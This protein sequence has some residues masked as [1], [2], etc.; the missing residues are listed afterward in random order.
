MSDQR[1]PSLT[2]MVDF[3]V[4]GGPSLVPRHSLDRDVVA[5][6]RRLGFEWSILKA[7]EGST[8]ERA[9]LAGPGAVGGIVLNASVGGANPAAIE[10]AARYGARIVWM[11]TISA[12]AHRAAHDATELAILRNMPLSEVR[13]VEDGRL[14]PAW[15][16]VLDIVVARDLVLASGHIS[17]GEAVVLFTEAKRRGV[18]RMLINHPLM[19]F[20]GWDRPCSESLRKLGVF[21]ELGILPDL[22]QQSEA[23]SSLQL[24]KTY[25][26]E[27][28]V[29]G[30]DLGHAD[31]PTLEEALPRWL[32]KLFAMAGSASAHLIMS[33]N[34]LALLS[35]AATNSPS[36]VGARGSEISV[37]AFRSDSKE[38]VPDESADPAR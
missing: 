17:C 6:N 2:R 28:L 26:T 1:P 24:L 14:L 34:G 32:D 30:S 37:Q 10:I 4:H 19:P 18:R 36:D 12:S 5:A 20:L 31:Y 16:D 27:Q 25:P 9:L 29:F 8:A 13:V 11:P 23:R 21:L 22:L 38:V 35:P 7:H 33:Q 15:G 3:H